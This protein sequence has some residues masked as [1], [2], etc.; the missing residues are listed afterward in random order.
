M[1]PEQHTELNISQEHKL[2]LKYHQSE[3][4]HNERILKHCLVFMWI[5]VAVLIAGFIV[6]VITGKNQMTAF[7]AGAFVDLFS[8]GIITLVN[9]SS[10][11]KQKYFESINSAE[12][13][14]RLIDELE[15]IDDPERKADLLG[16][17][18][19]GHYR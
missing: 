8:G 18:I 5:G 16:R 15:H 4:D 7:A 1:V 17:I 10:D 9:K 11:S 12:N 13:E 14:Q 3:I 2:Y 19:D 6:S